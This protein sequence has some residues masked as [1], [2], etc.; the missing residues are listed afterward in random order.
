[1]Q[2]RCLQGYLLLCHILYCTLLDKSNVL[3]QAVARRI[4]LWRLTSTLRPL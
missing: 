3:S 2:V 4:L 1:M